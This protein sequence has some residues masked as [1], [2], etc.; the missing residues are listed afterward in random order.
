MAEKTGKTA[1]KTRAKKSKKTGSKPKEDVVN[2][3]DFIKIDYVGQVL[4]TGEVFDTTIKEKAVEAGLGG[5]DSRY[6]PILVVVGEKW[7]VE[8]LD[9][10][11]IGRKVGEEY[12]VEIPPEKG[13]GRRDSKKI[14][15]TTIRKLQ[16]AGLQGDI[17]PGMVIN[18]DGAPAVVRA[19]AG[20][21]VMLD[22]NPPLAGKR[23]KY[24]VKI[25]EKITDLNGK[26][27]ALVER[28]FNEDVE[29]VS[30]EIVDGEVVLNLGDLA[31]KKPQLHLEKKHVADD[32][33]KYIDG[34]KAV[35]FVD[36]V[37]KEEA[38]QEAQAEPQQE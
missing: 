33:L 27:K 15:T 11:L 19:I 21:R 18:V 8:G 23:L 9:E 16:R 20:G 32:I 24:W 7:V 4:D 13:F 34:T 5:D 6:K 35:K 22:F 26:I 3:G 37:A 38:V 25:R 10:S 29:K 14:V 30:I 28:H 2:K 12:E 1:K 31:I 17:A 36:V